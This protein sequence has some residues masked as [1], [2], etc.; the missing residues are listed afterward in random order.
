LKA[1]FK[2][3]T[4]TRKKNQIQLTATTKWFESP[5]DHFY[6]D[7]GLAPTM[8]LGNK[9]IISASSIYSSHTNNQGYAGRI[10]VNNV[11]F[12]L[13]QE[14]T[15][16]NIITFQYLFSSY[17]NLNFRLRDYWS[18]VRYDQYYELQS[19]G[20]LTSG[21]YNGNSDVNLNIFNIDM[22]YTWQY[23]PG[24]FLSLSWKSSLALNNKSRED[25]YFKSFSKTLE[26]PK[27]TTL[28][29]R[30]IYYLDY[31]RL[32]KAFH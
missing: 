24:S 18:K 14:H 5:E 10:D 31:L 2:F 32:R 22:V 28:S 8:R 20:S 4:D 13:R 29:I 11:V 30:L 3:S 27:N 15:V 1:F 26:T 23:A 12:G 9:I 6:F 19:D 25:E 7:V 17:S 21:S 16:E